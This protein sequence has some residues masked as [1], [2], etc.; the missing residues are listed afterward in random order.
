MFIK[1]SNKNLSIT[2]CKL[3]FKTPINRSLNNGDYNWIYNI[4]T[5]N[6]IECECKNIND[7]KSNK[8]VKT[9]ASDLKIN[10]SLLK[11]ISE[12]KNNYIRQ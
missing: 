4:G 3:F 12:L 11:Q 8:K 2:L 5:Y 6:Y 7:C 1:I 10:L 9:N